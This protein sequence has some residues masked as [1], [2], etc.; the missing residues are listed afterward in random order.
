MLAGWPVPGRDGARR[1]LVA[2]FHEPPP[3]P[4]AAGHRGVDLAT[5]PR[6][7]VRAAAPGRIVFAGRVAG[8]GVVSVELDGGAFPRLRMTYEPARPA[9]AVG[10]RVTAGQLLG[11]L[12]PGLRP[13]PRYH[14]AVPCLHWGLLRGDRYLD[15]LSTLPP[16]LL[17][18]APSRLLPTGG[19]PLPPDEP[20]SPVR[21][22]PW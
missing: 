20:A 4:W 17:R 14:C 1:P 15:P 8:R 21:G 3:Q 6:A 19:V 16:R 13:G 11:R 18:R 7:P 10:E 2:R 5:A 12:A 9:V 22:R